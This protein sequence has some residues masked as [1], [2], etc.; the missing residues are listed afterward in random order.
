M[1]ISGAKFEERCPNITRDIVNWLLYCFSRTIYDIITFLF[2]I[3]QKRKYLYN[4]NR[5]S[6]KENATLLYFENPFK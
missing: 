2:G 6:K 4:E 1:R 3:I 5:Y